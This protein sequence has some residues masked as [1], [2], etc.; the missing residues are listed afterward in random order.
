[1]G[2]GEIGK[3]AL[4]TTLGELDS[5]NKRGTEPT[6]LRAKSKASD[7]QKG[8]H[9]RT[10]ENPDLGLRGCRDEMGEARSTAGTMTAAAAISEYTVYRKLN[11]NKMD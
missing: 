6:D 7:E 9:P 8:T 2:F 5:G 1:M 10:G 3:K 11:D 4:A